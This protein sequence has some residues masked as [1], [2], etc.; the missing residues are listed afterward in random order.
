M[1]SET[2]IGV[3]VGVLNC[4]VFFVIVPFVGNLCKGQCGIFHEGK[5][6]PRRNFTISSASTASSVTALRKNRP[7]WT[8]LPG[9]VPSN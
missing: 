1:D 2:R 3:S 8:D 7:W 9:S 4:S 5:E 6:L